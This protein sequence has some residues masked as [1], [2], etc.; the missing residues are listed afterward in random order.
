MF[1]V[2][3]AAVAH[4]TLIVTVMAQV[5]QTQEMAH[6]VKIVEIPRMEAM[7]S[8]IGQAEAVEQVG[9]ALINLMV[10]RVVQVL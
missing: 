3:L 5:V 9:Q 8:L 1:M 10:A 6:L 2:R 7:V 4:T